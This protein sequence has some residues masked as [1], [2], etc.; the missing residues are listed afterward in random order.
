LVLERGEMLYDG[1]TKALWESK[2]HRHILQ[3]SGLPLPRHH[4]LRRHLQLK[5]REMIDIPILKEP[6]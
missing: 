6:A 1:E 3:E 4:R 2:E 5:G